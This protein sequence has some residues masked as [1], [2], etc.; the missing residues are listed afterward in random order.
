[1]SCQQYP[2][3]EGSKCLDCW[4]CDTVLGTNR[5]VC[6]QTYVRGP[7][8]AITTCQAQST[9]SKPMFA[10]KDAC[11]D[12]CSNEPA[13]PITCYM[14]DIQPDQKVGKC[15]TIHPTD[16][17]GNYL[18]ECPDWTNVFPTM[19]ACK[20]Q[21]K[22]GGHVTPRPYCWTA[23]YPDCGCVGGEVI[24]ITKCDPK[25]GYFTSK[26]VCE[27]ACRDAFKPLQPA[28]TRKLISTSIVVVVG[29][30]VLA[31]IAMLLYLFYRRT[32]V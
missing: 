30:A 11:L 24:G 12:A 20:A 9:E 28:K 13:P 22:E 21:C 14:C 1:M 7:S 27:K 15:F 5:R 17:K 25:K 8:S 6:T 10:S 19:D 2:P 4:S 23:G 18:K 29:V 26:A 3:P 32:R 31:A 16:N